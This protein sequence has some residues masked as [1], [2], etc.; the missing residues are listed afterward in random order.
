[1]TPG[2]DSRAGELRRFAS[3]VVEL[4][5]PQIPSLSEAQATLFR[6]LRDD[7]YLPA[8]VAHEALLA[9]AGR[10]VGDQSLL[11]EEADAFEDYRLNIEVDR[12]A[13][14][15][16]AIPVPTRFERWQALALACSRHPRLSLRLR[17]LKAG[18]EIERKAVAD[19]SPTVSRLADDLLELF[20]LPPEVRAVEARAR[21]QRFL[22][23]PRLKPAEKS[24][25][26]HQ[27]IKRHSSVASLGPG[28]LW[29]IS[30]KVNAP[31]RAPRANRLR[32]WIGRA[33]HH[34][35]PDHWPRN[36]A[37][38]LVAVLCLVRA[39]VGLDERRSPKT[40]SNRQ[41]ASQ[42]PLIQGSSLSSS[43][44]PGSPVPQVLVFQEFKKRLRGEIVSRGKAINDRQLN[45]V[46]AGLTLD[47]LPNLKDTTSPII[48]GRWTKV[49]RD[50]FVARL[51][52]MLQS[53]DLDLAESE[54]V[55]VARRCLPA[56]TGMSIEQ[57]P[58]SP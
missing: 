29:R 28:Y 9:L 27:L 14:D 46:I 34:R 10:P 18:L 58:G 23:D 43:P 50:L 32:T 54:L 12:L 11:A 2:D 26:V 35:F 15:F 41:V 4:R 51:V 6:K 30:P 20:P 44:Q 8:P 39:F 37:L 56:P 49:E 19:P 38:I 21:V 24:R 47:R 36:F 48:L 52:E 3:F 53:V 31:W 7:D 25:A 1:M 5:K 16:F 57:R 45:Q 42:N 22:A 13:S 40:D 33:L 55:E 17:A